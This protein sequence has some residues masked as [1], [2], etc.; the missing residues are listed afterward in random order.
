MLGPKHSKVTNQIEIYEAVA[1]PLP[2]KK[3]F[4]PNFLQRRQSAHRSRGL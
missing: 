4:I 2:K 3:R 1:L